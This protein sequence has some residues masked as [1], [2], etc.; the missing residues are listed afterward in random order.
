MFTTHSDPTRYFSVVGSAYVAER[1]FD[2][3]DNS[4]PCASVAG[5]EPSLTASWLVLIALLAGISVFAGEI[6]V[7]ANV[8]LTT[9]VMASAIQ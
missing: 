3:D 8:G 7:L 5:A 4:A 6:S 9:D 2:S 1:H